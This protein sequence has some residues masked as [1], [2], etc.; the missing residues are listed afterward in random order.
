MTCAIR[1]AAA[2]PRCGGWTIF[3][4][5]SHKAECTSPRVCQ[6]RI[7]A[8]K[9]PKLTAA[10][11]RVLAAMQEIITPVLPEGFSYDGIEI[12]NAELQNVNKRWRKNVLHRKI[13]VNNI[14]RS[15]RSHMEYYDLIKSLDKPSLKS[16][17]V[18][19]AH[20]RWATHGAPSNKNA[21]PHS[22]CL[23]RIVL[24]HNGIM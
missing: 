1:N 18:G 11:R 4:G 17:S 14:N 8:A 23:V 12:F 15:I 16:G 2:C 22:D 13:V 3:G 24:V 5:M 19:L 20:N 7:D 9:A 10:A 6:Q 21:H